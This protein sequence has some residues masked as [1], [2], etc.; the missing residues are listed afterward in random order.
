MINLS[1][2]K[3]GNFSQLK[4]E[5]VQIIG[6]IE[7]HQLGNEIMDPEGNKTELGNPQTASLQKCIPGNSLSNQ[8][9]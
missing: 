1:S 8:I 9:S 5:G 7:E 4:K 3:P 6:E 2:G